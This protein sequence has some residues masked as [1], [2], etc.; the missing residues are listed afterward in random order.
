MPKEQKQNSSTPEGHIGV[1]I[2]TQQ[3]QRNSCI[4]AKTMC[5]PGHSLILFSVLIQSF[6]MQI[7]RIWAGQKKTSSSRERI[8]QES[9]LTLPTQLVFFD[10]SHVRLTSKKPS[11]L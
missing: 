6:H 2:L 4:H 1:I 10:E 5:N 7:N 9:Y 3:R 8:S 11:L